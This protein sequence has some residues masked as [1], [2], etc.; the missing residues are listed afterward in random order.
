MW[1]VRSHIKA[2][3]SPNKKWVLKSSYFPW[4]LHH[5]SYMENATLSKVFF[6]ETKTQILDFLFMLQISKKPSLTQVD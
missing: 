4:V 3:K 1:D 2:C 5:F 6:Q